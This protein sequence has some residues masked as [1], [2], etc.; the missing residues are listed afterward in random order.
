MAYPAFII[1][2]SGGTAEESHLVP[3]FQIQRLHRKRSDVA[4]QVE[5][6]GKTQRFCWL[7]Q[8]YSV[9]VTLLPYF[10]SPV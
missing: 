7:F 1:D 3:F 6:E 4:G 9:T 8:P 10:G 5:E 2:Y